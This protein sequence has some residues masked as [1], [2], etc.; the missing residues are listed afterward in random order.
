MATEKDVINA[1][2]KASKLLAKRGLGFRI[3]N[4]VTTRDK[5]RLQKFGV[6]TNVRGGRWG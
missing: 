5:K 2:K 4:P 3:L 1:L 6:T